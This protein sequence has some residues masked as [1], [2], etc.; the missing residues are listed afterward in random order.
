VTAVFAGRASPH[1]AGQTELQDESEN[2]I[3]KLHRKGLIVIP[4]GFCPKSSVL[5]TPAPRLMSMSQAACLP[6][7][8]ARC[9]GVCF[10]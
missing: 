8:A 2:I 9:S 7:E 6:A 4:T 1:Q 5:S 10:F 3:A